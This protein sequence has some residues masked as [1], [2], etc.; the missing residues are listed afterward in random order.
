MLKQCG[1]ILGAMVLL[2]CTPA[3][4]KNEVSVAPSANGKVNVVAS[5]SILGDITQE[6]GGDRVVVTSLVGANQDA[7]VYQPSPADVKTVAQAQVVVRNGLGLDDN[8][9]RLL[10]SA[11]F[12]GITVVATQGLQPLP[13]PS[14]GEIGHDHE[15]DHAGLG[16]PHAWGDPNIVRTVYI[17]NIVAG[18]SQA[19]PANAFYYQQRGQAY[20]A[21]LA[22]VDT[23]IKQQFAVIPPEQRK[24]VTSHDAFAY[25]ARA[26][27][28]T[29]LAPQGVST[30]AE[31][32][33]K[34]VGE[35]IHQIR[36]THIKALFVEN[37]SDP[38]LIH[39]I[40][41]ESGIKVGGALYSDALS[42]P[43]EAAPTYLKLLVHNADLL[44][45]AMK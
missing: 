22:T 11:D 35:L 30:E 16:D 5:F 44:V 31:A 27:G 29:F 3:S 36:Q 1:M 43:N 37:I 34:T 39:Q 18:L 12:K 32:S 6:I 41:Q 45:Q 9:N 28:I 23:R 26:Y 15:H 8:V 20:A 38:K 33:A 14:H 25:F 2:A 10:Q 21:Q 24:A 19:D 17:P 4:K 13:M 7:H 42:A 40:E